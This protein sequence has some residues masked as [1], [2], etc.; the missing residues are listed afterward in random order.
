MKSLRSTGSAVAC[1]RAEEFRLA[2]EPGPVGKHRQAGRTAGFI[3]FGKFWRSKW[4]G[5]VPLTGSP[6]SSPRSAQFAAGDTQPMARN[7][8]GGAAALACASRVASRPSSFRFRDFGALIGFDFR[9]EGAFSL[10]DLIRK[11]I[12]TFR[13]HALRIHRIGYFDQPVEPAFGLAAVDR[14]G[15]Q[16]GAFFQ[17]LALAG[18]DQC[19][20]CIQNGHVA[21]RARFTFEHI[22]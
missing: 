11:P 15:R 5:S 12:P 19:R 9:P 14:F 13:D 8:R 22:K 17:I 10:H 20:C 6:S 3:G 21:E 2:L 18:D 1:V 16:R 7:P 4:R